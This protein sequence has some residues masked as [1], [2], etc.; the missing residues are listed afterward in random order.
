MIT[1]DTARPGAGHPMAITLEALSIGAEPTRTRTDFPCLSPAKEPSDPLRG[2]RSGNA[3]LA[4][5]FVSSA[6]DAPD[7][8]MMYLELHLDLVSRE[9]F[10]VYGHAEV[11][12]LRVN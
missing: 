3:E 7:E 1:P 5:V 6:D 2:E 11:V 4:D 9:T 10:P 8:F 12:S